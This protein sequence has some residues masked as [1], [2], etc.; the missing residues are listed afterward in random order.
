VADAKQ[1][2][3]IRKKKAGHAGAHG[4]AWKVAL[5]DFM[6]AMMCFFLVMWLMGSDEETKAAVA[7]YFNN[8]TSALRIDLSNS[9]NV[10]LGDRTGA[11]E[12]VL[13]G[14][15]GEV[16][17]ELVKQP[18][19]PILDGNT[20]ADE[21]ADALTKLAS[22]GDRVLVEV[23]RFSVLEDDLFQP[24]STNQ[25]KPGIESIFHRIGKLAKNQTRTK[26]TIRG[27]WGS[28]ETGDYDFQVARTVAV[29]RYLVGRRLVEEERIETKM[30]RSK[31][32]DE[33]D[34]RSPA[35]SSP[36][37]EFIFQ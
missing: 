20:S 18:S 5:A 21:A 4:G 9:M 30:R 8:P 2:I 23:M 3:I 16:P 6:T 31:S 10:P 1:P 14:A 11:G 29:A 37:I 35:G 28:A 27:S 32:G 13:R 12:S 34:S 17:E 15:D 25:W 33:S 36:R 7:D 26:L 24:G 22:S 19:R